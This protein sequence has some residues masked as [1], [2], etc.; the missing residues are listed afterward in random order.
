MI[1]R[2]DL[3]IRN[4]IQVKNVL[5]SQVTVEQVLGH[6]DTKIKNREYTRTEQLNQSCDKIAKAMR[7][8]YTMPTPNTI[9]GEGL[10]IWMENK[11]LYN[12]FGK[13]IRSQY[14][15]QK[16]KIVICEQYSWNSEQFHAIQWDAN[17]KAMEMLSRPHVIW[18]SKY[19]THFLPIGRNM[20]RRTDWKESYCSRCSH[21]EETHRHLIRCNE[22]MSVQLFQE[23]LNEF[24]TVLTSLQTPSTL[25]SQ[26]IVMISMWRSDIDQPSA[27]HLEPPLQ[28][29]LLLG[30]FDH[31][32]EGRIH[33]EFSTYM[34]K[35]YSSIGSLKNGHQWSKIV[36]QRIWSLLYLPMWQLRNKFVHKI[37]IKKVPA[38]RKRED[39]QSRIREKYAQEAKRK[40]LAKDQHLYDLSVTQ[41]Q[42]LSNDAMVGWLECFKLAT[43]DR[44]K[45]FDAEN[46]Q[47]QRTLRS[48]VETSETNAPTAPTPRPSP[49]VTHKHAENDSRWNVNTSR[50]HLL[51]TG[52]WKPP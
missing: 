21:C 5:H 50:K 51:R 10:A 14:Y 19:I 44:D 24:N 2:L 20:E 47:F 4:V 17:E 28:S 1:E 43:R 13:K 39:L 33:I 12:D 31:F 6:A 37:D 36:I 41:L 9:Q 38:S 27:K 46:L 15:M 48:W 30:A 32:M 25:Q 45:I 7:G 8:K 52:T 34:D 42:A 11:K 29:Q 3:L 40:L 35:H 23:K 22:D 18:V 26:I 49:T 16:A